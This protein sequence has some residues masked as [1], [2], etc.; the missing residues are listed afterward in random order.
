MVVAGLVAAMIPAAYPG[1]RFGVI[2]FAVCAVRGGR[3]SIRSRWR[4]WRSS[5]SLIYNGFL[6]DRFGQLAWHGAD[7]LWRLLLLVIAGAWGLAVG[8]G[9]RFVRDLR[10]P[11]SHGGRHRAVRA[12]DREEKHGA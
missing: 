4:W 10:V 8:E 3:R 2:A 9:Y 5:A 1:W 12:I 6:E 7:D 11:P